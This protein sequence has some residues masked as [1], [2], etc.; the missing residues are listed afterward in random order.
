MEDT[1]KTDTPDKLDNSSGL[2]DES[3][4]GLTAENAEE[5]V[6]VYAQRNLAHITVWGQL[7][8]PNFVF[9]A[10]AES[11]EKAAEGKPQHFGLQCYLDCYTH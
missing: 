1:E 8:I 4:E 10:A 6:S 11:S 5:L 9:L 3:E 7:L 2:T